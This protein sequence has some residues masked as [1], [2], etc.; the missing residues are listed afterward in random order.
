[1]EAFGPRDDAGLASFLALPERVRERCPDCLPP[2][3]PAQT[4]FLRSRREPVRL[5]LAR[6]ADGEP[7][8]R[9]A[10]FAGEQTCDGRRLGFLGCFAA[11]DREG[12]I[13]VLRAG[14]AWLGEQ[15]AEQVIGPLDGDTWHS[16]RLN[17]GPYEPGPFLMEP[18]HPPAWPAW[19]EAAGFAPWAEYESQVVV[20]C[21]AAGVRFGKLADRCRRHGYTLR[22]IDLGAY[23][24]E[25]DR[26]H[27]LSLRC[28]AD[29]LL[30]QPLDR[31]EFGRLYGD[32]AKL[33]DP[34]LV[35]FALAP[36]GAP[37]GFLFCLPDAHVALVAA[38]RGEAPDLPS[39][40]AA[41]PPEA[42]NVKTLA[43]L[44]AHQRRGVA[45]L[46][47]ARA[48]ALVAELGLSR[49]NLCLMHQANASRRY[50]TSGSH[51]LRR[52]AL[53]SRIP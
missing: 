7:R 20:D 10:A 3:A 43:V 14:C 32:L 12:A 19:W 40:L 44:P 25:L 9:V 28:F 29:N 16:Y 50:G 53:F 21:A 27:E 34:R 1:M 35:Q 18:W 15:G 37:V 49:A 24:H 33:P 6:T 52:Y 38:A 51:Q 45:A 39:A 41:H 5:F 22:P 47:M 11:T 4:A 46:L 31:A 17:L 8:A 30:Y 2:S 26:L 42:L 36:D 23:E 48:Y 13:A